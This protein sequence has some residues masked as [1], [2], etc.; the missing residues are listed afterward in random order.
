MSADD[1]KTAAPFVCV[2]AVLL[3]DGRALADA[4]YR[5]SR[6]ECEIIALDEPPMPGVDPSSIADEVWSVKTAQQWEELSAIAEPR[7]S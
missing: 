4:C 5:G 1:S 3:K 6:A 2:R 7:V